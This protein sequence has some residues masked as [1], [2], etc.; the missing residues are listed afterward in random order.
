VPERAWGFKSPL[1]QEDKPKMASTHI[2]QRYGAQTHA[3][4]HL[5]TTGVTHPV[6]GGVAEKSERDPCRSRWQQQ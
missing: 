2:R 6:L 1:G 5:T 3:S 4:R